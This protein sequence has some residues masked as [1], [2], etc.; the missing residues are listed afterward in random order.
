[1]AYVRERARYRER[2]TLSSVHFY[3]WVHGQGRE[4]GFMPFYVRAADDLGPTPLHGFGKAAYLCNEGVF[5]LNL[6][7]QVAP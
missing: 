6:V 2:L 1:V 3:K 4:L 5:V 7:P